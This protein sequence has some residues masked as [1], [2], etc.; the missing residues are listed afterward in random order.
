MTALAGWGERSGEGEGVGEAEEFAR[1]RGGD[2]GVGGEAIEVIEAGTGRPGGESGFAELSELSLEAIEN[3]AG[4]RIAGRDG[5]TRARIAAL[6]G[7]FTDR[8]A[9][10]A[11]FLFTE[12]TIFPEGRQL[13]AGR[14]ACWVEI[15]LEGGAE[16]LASFVE[17][18]AREPF[19]AWSEPFGDG[20]KR[21]GGDDGGAVGDGVVRKTAGGIADDNLLLEEN[22]EPFGSV[23]IGFGEG[24]SVRGNATAVTRSGES[25]G[26]EVGRVIGANEVDGGS[27]LAVDPFAVDGIESPD[28]VESESAGGTDASLGNGDGVEGFDGMETDECEGRNG[29]REECSRGGIGYQ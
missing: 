29:H 10:D 27:A 7:D 20:L 16:T 9:D 22:A 25:D 15:D 24:K 3:G 26:A 18:D 17:G 28:T 13:F 2:A 23:F 5:A 4:V 11:A 12:E 8:E 21:S 1:F 6:E 14:G 19:G